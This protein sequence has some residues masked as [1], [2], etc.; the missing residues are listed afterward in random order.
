MMIK[1]EEGC[2]GG[3]WYQYAKYWLQNLWP[4]DRRSVCCCWNNRTVRASAWL[5]SQFFNSYPLNAY[6]TTNKSINFISCIWRYYCE[7]DTWKKSWIIEVSKLTHRNP[8]ANRWNQ[9]VT[10][11]LV[12]VY[13]ICGVWEQ[14]YEAPEALYGLTSSINRSGALKLVGNQ[15]NM[16]ANI[17]HSC[18]IFVF[19]SGSRQFHW[20]WYVSRH[21][22]RCFSVLFLP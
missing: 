1:W 22:I 7:K 17:V 2:G 3:V 9:R 18:Q 6:N 10:S 19:W 21:Y 5:T 16:D 20:I 14:K 11:S 15:N 4:T 8:V 12:S 13:P